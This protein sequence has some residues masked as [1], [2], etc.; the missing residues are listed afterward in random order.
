MPVD[1]RDLFLDTTY[2]RIHPHTTTN[3]H[4][5]GHLAMNSPN[6]VCFFNCSWVHKKKDCSK[7]KTSWIKCITSN[8]LNKL[9][10]TFHISL[11]IQ[12]APASSTPTLM[13]NLNWILGF[14]IQTTKISI[15]IQVLIFDSYLKQFSLSPPPRSPSGPIINHH[16]WSMNENSSLLIAYPCFTYQLLTAVVS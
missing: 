6:N 16:G 7:K 10:L 9:F 13:K 2:Y 5:P 12:N 3:C 1:S 15:S 14:S 4:Q 8:Q 11:R